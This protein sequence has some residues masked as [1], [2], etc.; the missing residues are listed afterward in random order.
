[1]LDMPRPRKPYTHRETTRHGGVVWYF[2]KGK[3]Q[4]IRLHG[5]YESPEWLADYADALLGVVRDQPRKRPGPAQGTLGWLVVR[6]QQS[7]EWANLAEATKRQR[8]S[9]LNRVLAENM[10]TPLDGNYILDS[11]LFLG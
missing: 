8:K 11:R 7:T 2:R 3:G 6:Y 4:R 9:V 10:S 1:M 5:D